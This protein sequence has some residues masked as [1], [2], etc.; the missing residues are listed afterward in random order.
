MKKISLDQQINFAAPCLFTSL[1]CSIYNFITSSCIPPFFSPSFSDWNASIYVLLL[2]VGTQAQL[3][4]LSPS[5]LL[6]NRYIT[7]IDS[8][9]AHSL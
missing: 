9:G 8:F 2:P 5:E 7:V 3:P 6:T 4:S 1:F